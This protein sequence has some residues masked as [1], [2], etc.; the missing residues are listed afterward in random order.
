MEISY[1][2]IENDFCEFTIPDGYDV[3]YL[4]SNVKVRAISSVWKPL[5]YATTIR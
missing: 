4:P 5:T 3:E 1:K 2:Y